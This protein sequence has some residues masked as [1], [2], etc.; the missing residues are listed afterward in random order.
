MINFLKNLKIKTLYIFSLIFLFIGFYL[1]V[2][3]IPVSVKGLS[4]AQKHDLLIEGSIN[5]ELGN[6]FK[7]VALVILLIAII[8]TI[9]LIAHKKR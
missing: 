5:W 8:K 1:S 7:I 3:W 6:F 4:K 9:K 2:N